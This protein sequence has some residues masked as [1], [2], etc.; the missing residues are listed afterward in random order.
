MSKNCPTCGKKLNG[1]YERK[2]KGDLKTKPTL[3]QENAHP[4]WS[5]Q[6]ITYVFSGA[7]TH[8]QKKAENAASRCETCYKKVLVVHADTALFTAEGSVRPQNWLAYIHLLVCMCGNTAYGKAVDIMSDYY[9]VSSPTCYQWRV[10]LQ[11]FCKLWFLKL[12]QTFKLGGEG[13][14]CQIDETHWSKGLVS[15]S[16]APKDG[17]NQ[18]KPV[19]VWAV[20]C[21]KAGEAKRFAFRMLPTTEEAEEGKPR[22]RLLIMDAA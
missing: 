5:T 22:G 9:G 2:R 18:R 21:K 13:W 16:M 3:I 17:V 20:V 1:S 11:E 10:W 7:T 19:W 12:D 4:N 15:K 14:N 8:A 6:A